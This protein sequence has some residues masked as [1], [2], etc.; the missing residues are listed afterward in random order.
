MT[1]EGV[2][3]FRPG[4]DADR[5]CFANQVESMSVGFRHRSDAG[6]GIG[7]TDGVEGV[8]DGA[9]EL[10]FGNLPG[11]ITCRETFTQA[12]E[13]G[14]CRLGQAASMIPTPAFPQPPPEVPST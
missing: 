3:W 13:A 11:R 6:D 12:L 2:D 10:N 5:L 7:H 8:G 9:A 1:S 14:H 4:S